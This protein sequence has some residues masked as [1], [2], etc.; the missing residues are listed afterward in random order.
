M[1]TKGYFKPPVL[2][3]LKKGKAPQTLFFKKSRTKEKAKTF[4]P[5]ELSD[6]GEIPLVLTRS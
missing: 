6:L 2:R 1:I 3:N 4:S 5:K